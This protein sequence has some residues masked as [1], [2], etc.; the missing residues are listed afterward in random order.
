MIMSML[1][2]PIIAE[3]WLSSRTPSAH[4][5]MRSLCRLASAREPRGHLE[6]HDR[7]Y[8][9]YRGGSNRSDRNFKATRTSRESKKIAEGGT[10]I[11]FIEPNTTGSRPSDLIGCDIGLCRQHTKPHPSQHTRKGWEA[12]ETPTSEVSSSVLKC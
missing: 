5:R 7:L 6:R 2:K 4:S 10:G 9:K 11:L 12:K 3:P 8:P 1:I